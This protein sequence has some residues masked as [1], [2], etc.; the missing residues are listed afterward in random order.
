MVRRGRRHGDQ[1]V[2]LGRDAAAEITSPVEGVFRIRIAPKARAKS[3]RFP[4]LA[5]CRG[6]WLLRH[7]VHGVSDRP[8]PRTDGARRGGRRGVRR[9]RREDRADRQARPALHVLEQ[10]RVS[11]GAAHRS[12][13]LRVASFTS[14]LR[15]GP[16]SR[17]RRTERSAH[18]RSHD[19]HAVS[20]HV[21]VMRG[22]RAIANGTIASA[23]AAVAIVATTGDVASPSNP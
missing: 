21:V 10:G 22:A 17:S 11:A 2:P 15:V 23:V 3:P 18:G 8:A 4:E 14:S 9:L 20:V 6:R 16:S 5:G 1:R 19:D 7:G 12:F 13:F